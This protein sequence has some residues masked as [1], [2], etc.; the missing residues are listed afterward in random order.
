[1]LQF[2]KVKIARW[3][4]TRG[5]YWLELYREYDDVF[6][7]S[8]SYRGDSSGGFIGFRDIV[9][10]LESTDSAG[11]ADFVSR[12]LHDHFPGKIMRVW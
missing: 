12:R 4:S 9:G 6:S 7:P 3:E 5:K 2:Q 11:I 8:Y 10:D 1:M